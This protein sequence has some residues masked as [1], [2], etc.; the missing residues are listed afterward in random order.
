MRVKRSKGFLGSRMYDEEVE[1]ERPLAFV[2]S[3]NTTSN[4]NPSSGGGDQGEGLKLNKDIK[5]KAV[6]VDEEIKEVDYGKFLKYFFLIA[7]I[8]AVIVLIGS[9]IVEF[10]N[11]D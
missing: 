5:N 8:I 1:E 11:A 2:V 9:Q 10:Q 4:K 7:M 6:K 3:Q